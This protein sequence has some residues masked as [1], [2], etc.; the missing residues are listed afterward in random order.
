[1]FDSNNHGRKTKEV[2]SYYYVTTNKQKYFFLLRDYPV[3]ANNSDNIGLYS[4][5]VVKKEYET[6]IWDG[7]QKIIY[8][9]NQKIPYV[10]IYIPLE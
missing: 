3:D 1:V 5:L 9:G 4:L 7:N 6:K 10:G 2:H 8:D